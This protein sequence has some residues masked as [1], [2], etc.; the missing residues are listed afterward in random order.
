MKGNSTTASELLELLSEVTSGVE[1]FAAREKAL[2]RSVQIRESNARE[3]VA[4]EGASL[5]REY[6]QLESEAREDHQKDVTALESSF[7]ARHRRLD[8][9]QIQVRNQVIE[10]YQATEGQKK[11]RLQKEFMDAGER[12]ERLLGEAEER[13]QHDSAEAAD[14]SQTLVLVE[15]EAVRALRGFREL[16]RQL[17]SSL[18]RGLPVSDESIQSDELTETQWMLQSQ[19]NGFR[20]RALVSWFNALPIALQ[21]FLAILLIGILPAGL[22]FAGLI[23]MAFYI[24]LTLSV[25]PVV[26]ALVGYLKARSAAAEFVASIEKKLAVAKR[27]R[28]QFKEE[29]GVR[30]QSRLQEIDREYREVKSA[31][32]SGIGT[33]GGELGG[34]GKYASP[35]AVE[36][37]ANRIKEAVS[38]AFNRRKQRI[39]R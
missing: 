32:D 19:V 30:H 2:G 25:V 3:A 38:E 4:A 11:A 10:G 16:Q 1:K 22:S 27:D 9:A 31:F 35:D 8:A 7:E 24:P 34:S 26:L 36:R 18:K 14:L 17:I 39:D 5:Q 21:L 6:K 37:R 15:K 20:G 12:R 23:D 13:F 33:G 28:L 29:V